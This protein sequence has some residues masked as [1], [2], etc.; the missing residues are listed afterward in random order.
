MN[1]TSTNELTFLLFFLL[2]VLLPVPLLL[3]LSLLQVRV[4]CEASGF[5]CHRP[6]AAAGAVGGSIRPLWKV[7]VNMFN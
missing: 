6:G 3:S 5:H 7:R 1:H 2:F 4:F